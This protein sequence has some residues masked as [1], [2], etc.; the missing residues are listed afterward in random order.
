MNRLTKVLFF[1][2]FL[3]LA[4]GQL[5]RLPWFGSAIN[6][7]FHDLIIIAILG[8]NLI[9]RLIKTRKIPSL[10]LTRPIIYFSPAWFPYS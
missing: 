8:L 7:Y 1:S 10:P 6:L 9:P 3:S 2:L 5:T 4:F